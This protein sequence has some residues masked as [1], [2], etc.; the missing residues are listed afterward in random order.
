MHIMVF[1]KSNKIQMLFCI[2]YELATVFSPP[3]SSL[4]LLNPRR[5][6]QAGHCCLPLIS[7]S[8]NIGGRL[9]LVIRS[10]LP[11]HL[12]G[13]V[14][15]R[16]WGSSGYRQRGAEL[17]WCAGRSGISMTFTFTWQTRAYSDTV[18]Q[19]PSNCNQCDCSS[20]H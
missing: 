14:D 17:N 5:D 18:V 4:S 16:I 2:H 3:S 12:P 1:Q 15:V 11:Q 10:L 20:F 8:V 9:A 7:E 19:C 13:D 6:G